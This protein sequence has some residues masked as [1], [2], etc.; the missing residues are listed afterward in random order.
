MEGASSLE[1]GVDVAAWIFRVTQ[2]GRREEGV[3]VLV[4]RT[5]QELGELLLR[6]RPRPNP[7]PISHFSSPTR[8]EF[9]SR[10]AEAKPSR[11]TSRGLRSPLHPR[12]TT[13][14]PSGRFTPS[15]R[16][17]RAGSPSSP[18]PRRRSSDSSGDEGGRRGRLHRSELHFTD[19]GIR[20]GEV[21]RGCG[22][23]LSVDEVGGMCGDQSKICFGGEYS[24]SSS[25]RSGFLDAER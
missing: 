6:L 13:A 16:R 9:V 23:D 18:T 12:S 21:I 22:G 4:Y 14:R 19:G 25:T 17:C 24:I 5:I 2:G 8:L 7:D 3:R 1:E 11:Q 15:E 20:E 10:R